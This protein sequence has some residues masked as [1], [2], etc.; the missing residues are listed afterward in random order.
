ML[1]EL[2]VDLSMLSNRLQV[3]Q[4]KLKRVK[5]TSLLIIKNVYS[6]LF[7]DL[8]ILLLSTYSKG[9][10]RNITLHNGLDNIKS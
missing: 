10:T 4:F 9:K 7:L 1:Y 6:L 5:L 2:L 3:L 8:F